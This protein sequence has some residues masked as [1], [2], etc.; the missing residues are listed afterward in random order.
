MTSHLENVFTVD[1]CRGTSRQLT[2]S[3]RYS[4]QLSGVLIVESNYQIQWTWHCY[5]LHIF[6]TWS[7]WWNY[8]LFLCI[9]LN[10]ELLD[11]LAEKQNHLTIWI[12]ASEPTTMHNVSVHSSRLSHTCRLKWNNQFNR[13]KNAGKG[14]KALC[15]MKS[16]SQYWEEM[17]VAVCQRTDRH[18]EAKQYAFSS[19]RGYV[20]Q[21]NRQKNRNIS[22]LH[23]NKLCLESQVWE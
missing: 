19:D 12:Q 11:K 4:L 23:R 15:T 3:K 7:A 20:S 13:L 22:L 10:L 6:A 16:V 17:L 14:W 8:F 21:K 5:S 18:R 9:D 1:L 2:V